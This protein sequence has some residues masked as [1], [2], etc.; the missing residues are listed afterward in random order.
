[1][2]T[3]PVVCMIRANTLDGV[4][5]RWNRGWETEMGVDICFAY[6]GTANANAS[7]SGNRQQRFF[8][9]HTAHVCA[10]AFDAAGAIM[11]SGQEGKQAIV[12]VLAR[13]STEYNIKS[14]RF[15]EFEEDQLVSCGRDSIRF[16]RLKAGQLRGM[17]IRLTAPDRRSGMGMLNPETRH[18]Y[19]ASAA[20]SVFE[21][22]YGARTLT[23]VYQLHS[24]AI[25]SLVVHDGFCVTG[26][27]DKQL[28]VW[29]MDFSD[30]LLEAEHEAPVTSVGTSH[31]GLRVCVGT[32]NGAIGVLDIPS[33]QYETLL[34][35]HVG[36]VNAVTTDPNRNEYCTA[37]SDG[38]IRVWSL[39][40]HT[41]LFEFHAPGEVVT[42]VA[43]HPSHYELAAGYQNGRVRVF[44]ISTTTLV[45]ELKQHR[46]PVSQ[47]LY[48]TDGAYLYSSGFDGGLCVYDVAAI[49][50][51]VKFLSSGAPNLKAS[52]LCCC[53]HVAEPE[54]QYHRVTSLVVFHA[55]SLEPYMKIETDA[56]AFTALAFGASGEDLWALTSTNRLDRYELREGQ[57]IQQVESAHRLDA[58]C[59]VTDST[60]RFAASGGDDQLVKLWSAALPSDPAKLQ[61]PACQA[62]VGHPS[63]VFGS[64]YMGLGLGTGS[65]GQPVWPM[66]DTPPLCSGLGTWD[67]DWGQ[68][69]GASLSGLCRT[70]LRC[71]P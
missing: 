56:D 52:V 9:G 13:H 29:P 3:D 15:S 22:S 37:S 45:Q 38:T 16:Y 33:H 20:G 41:Q 5:L 34:R 46:A 71:V 6:M 62:F 1:M 68:R 61:P 36:P 54:D 14:I 10:V 55:D 23:C 53:L 69:F 70:P 60:G 49:Y 47:V 12:T 63:A 31:D 67:L 42:C 11:A 30:Y 40:T 43:Y 58:H 35:S 48:G 65:W 17:S 21:V 7:A 57:L 25:N 26:S 4:E 19:V 2:P 27:D 39:D 24:A 64:G 44:D 32:E 66:S 59:L 8:I 51:P 18:V 50:Q 28:R